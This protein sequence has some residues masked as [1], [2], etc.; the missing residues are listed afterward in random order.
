MQLAVNDAP[1]LTTIGHEPAGELIAKVTLPSGQLQ[2]QAD[3]FLTMVEAYTIDSPES[4]QDAANERN[5]INDRHK[6]VEEQRKFLKEPALEQGKRIDGF[7][8]PVLET[9]MKARDIMG[10]KITDYT[11]AERRKQEQAER[12]AREKAEREAAAQRALAAKAEAE[13]NAKAEALRKQAE[14][15]RAAGNAGQAAKLESKAESAVAAGQQKA[16]ELQV[17]AELATAAPVAVQEAPKADGIGISYD[18]SAE[19]TDIA[20]LLRH[21][22]DKRPDLIALVEIKAS[23]LN[24]QARSLKGALDLPGVKLVKKP[25]ISDSRR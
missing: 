13:A 22:V 7:F 12:E 14:E 2:Q 16:A 3:R 11:E 15:L 10:R 19:V 8:K 21:I 20:A 1:S 9:L 25:R 23:G 5:E 4:L 17:A 24:Q 18:Y 6:A